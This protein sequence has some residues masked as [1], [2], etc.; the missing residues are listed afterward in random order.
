MLNDVGRRRNPTA[1]SKKSTDMDC[2]RWDSG[3]D[4][5]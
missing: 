1:V 4:P 5:E 3:I 2:H